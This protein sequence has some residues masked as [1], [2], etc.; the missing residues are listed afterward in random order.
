MQRCLRGFGFALV[1][2][3]VVAG[4]VLYSG[5]VS[6]AADEPH[7]QWL[8]HLLEWVRER[9]I[10]QASRTI[11][12]PKDLDAPQRLLAG[13]ADYDAMCVGCHLAPGIA[14]SDFTLG[15]YPTPPKLTEPRATLQGL[16]E[17]AAARRDFWIIK[18]GIKASGMPA[19]G[20]TH[21]DERIWNM[22]AFLKRLPDL[23]ENQYRIL[24]NR[25]G[26]R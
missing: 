20:K 3:A 1:V 7:A 21:D 26:D 18:H 24:T 4:W 9:S 2:V 15:L 8:Y 11:E 17:E 13:G 22:V 12:V 5:R 25:Q 6:V 23:N 10:T 19:W 14:E 16:S